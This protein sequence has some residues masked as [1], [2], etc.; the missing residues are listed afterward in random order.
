VAGCGGSANPRVLVE[1]AAEDDVQQ[2][3][4]YVREDATKN[5]LLHTD[6]SD[7][8]KT[9]MRMINGKMPDTPLRLGIKFPAPGSYSIFIVGAIGRTQGKHVDWS[10]P[11][12]RQY[13]W[14]QTIQVSGDAQINGI[15]ANVGMNDDIDLDVFPNASTWANPQHID[16]KLLD[17]NDMKELINPLAREVCG[18]GVDDDCD[19][20]DTPCVDSDGDGDPDSSDCKPMDPKI[21]HPT[22]A[23]PYPESANCCGYSLGK[24]GPDAS[25]DFGMDPLCH[26][27]TC[28]NNGVD[29]DCDGRD[30]PCSR[31][32]DC[33][34]SPASAMQP[35]GCTAPA[36]NP[37]GPDCN[38]CDPAISPLAPEICDG[39]DNNCNGFTDEVCV[40]CDL[41]GDGFERMGGGCPDKDDKHPGMVDCNDE[42]AGVY[43][44]STNTPSKLTKLG[45]AT[46]KGVEGGSVVCALRGTC[47]NKKP[48][49]TNQDADCNGM[50]HDGCPM[51]DADGDGYPAGMDCN[52]ADPTFFFGAPDY[53]G[54][55]KAQDCGQDSICD[56]DKDG[57]R[58]NADVDCDDNDKNIHPWATELCNGKDDDCDGLIDEGNPDTTGKALVANGAVIKCTTSSVGDCANTQGDCV[59][60]GASL[61]GLHIEVPMKRMICPTETLQNDTAPG[62]FARCY[63]SG[64]PAIQ[65]C[66]PNKPPHDDDCDGANDAPMGAQ[67]GFSLNGQPCWPAAT[68]QCKPGGKII[69]CKIAP[70]GQSSNCYLPFG[71][72]PWWQCDMPSTL[73]PTGEVCNG[74]DDDCN[75]ALPQNEQDLDKDGYMQCGPAGACAMSTAISPNTNMPLLCGDCQ[76]SVGKTGSVDN[77][78]IHPSAAELCNGVDDDCSVGTTDGAADCP[79]APPNRI[80]CG[81]AGCKNSGSDVNNCLGCNIVCSVAHGTPGCDAMKGCVIGSCN[82][83]YKDCDGQYA[84]GC[85]IDTSSDVN[86]CTGCGT[87]C[88]VNNGTPACVNSQCVVGSCGP[89]F[90]DCNNNPG[91]GC[92]IN[93]SSDVAHCG[94]CGMACSMNNIAATCSGGNCNGTCNNGFADCNNNKRTDGCEINLTNDVNNCGGCAAPCSGNNLAKTCSANM[95]TGMCNAGFLD[96]NN[97]KRTDGCEI[98]SQTD[99]SNCGGCGK[100]CSNNNITS[101]TCA[102]G[103]CNA[104]CNLGFTDCNN[105]KLSDGCEKNTAADLMNC[106]SCG[107]VCANANWANVATYSC[108]SGVCGILSCKAG[109]ADCDGMKANGCEVNTTND[110]AHCGSCNACSGKANVAS[111]S[112]TA[113]V[114]GIAT[115]SN[116]F[117]DCNSTYTDGCEANINSDPAHCGGCSACSG[118]A[119]VNTYSCTAGVCGISTCNGGYADCNTTYND[120]CEINTTND[121]AHCGSCNACSGKAQVMTYSCTASVCGIAMC[122]SG[123]ADC[124]TTYNDGCEANTNTDPA[125]CGGCSA[126]SGKAQVMTYSCAAGSCGISMCNS[127]YA[128]CDGMYANGCEVNTN[129]DPTHCGGCVNRNCSNN[130]ITTPTCSAGNCTGACDTGFGDCNTNK[131]SD[132]CE[133]TLGTTSNCAACGDDCTNNNNGH[134]CYMSMFCGCGSG[135]DCPVA[136]PACNGGQHMCQ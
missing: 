50:A 29:E 112:C 72:N 104:A 120:G 118:K 3:D 31:D 90:K 47:R 59:C 101:P 17:C 70:M 66:D 88:T 24:S 85:E 57:D 110:P 131:L 113:S 86:N 44:G 23:D 34:G 58:Y 84:N 9:G 109:F 89:P 98:N 53:C 33:D 135:S 49:G 19:G 103:M 1:I 40:K 123:Y 38:D 52:D 71:V 128:N 54:D 41:D 76:D 15:L 79:G 130:H 25:K 30:L 99:K 106:G 12:A 6:W 14:A 4:L 5:I 94:G 125:H 117:M 92:E 107:N 67:P 13:F 96:C 115:C 75:G 60:S 93:T 20:A 36:N 122:N 116:G 81:N 78:L 105:D 129:T 7:A 121:P 102:A 73:C 108:T 62:S 82:A 22:K 69:G 27:G 95:C 8:T 35:N 37:P 65:S 43:P 63:F 39:K 21:H 80:C 91:D 55:M 119:Q 61:A 64:Q 83:P 134:I 48:D 111:Y 133:V 10:D 28:D 74:F 68:G 18:D 132:G 114:C 56:N 126:C 2:Y 136:F 46:C 26:A 42:D 51:N 97:D 32:Q 16:A 11:T 124:N 87:K 127:G 45:A 100:V 77:K